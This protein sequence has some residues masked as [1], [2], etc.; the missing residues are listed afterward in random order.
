MDDP[1]ILLYCYTVQPQGTGLTRPVFVTVMV[2]IPPV[3]KKGALRATG[4]STE[5]IPNRSSAGRCEPGD[6]SGLVGPQNKT[7]QP[8]LL[9]LD[10]D[11]VGTAPS[12]PVGPDI[13]MDRIQPLGQYR[14]RRPVGTDSE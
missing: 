3:L 9:G 5:M 2:D 4:V 10:V 1:V 13:M 7:E 6:R 8:V 14:T 11:Q 12:G